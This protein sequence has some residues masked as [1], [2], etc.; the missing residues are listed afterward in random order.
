MKKHIVWSSNINIE[1]WKDFLMEE[2][3]TITDENEQYNLCIDMNNDYLDDERKNLDIQLNNDIICIA[4]IGR[5]NGRKIGYKIIESGNISDCLYDD[6]DFCEWYVD[7][8]KNLCFSGDHHDGHNS[9]VYRKFK[10]ISN[11]QKENFLCKLYEGKA[12]QKNIT[13]YTRRI[14]DKICTVYGW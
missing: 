5:W 9:Y 3:P 8:Y 12:T 10:D 6:C 1:D 14:G 2:Y 11:E 13:R 4:N 7:K